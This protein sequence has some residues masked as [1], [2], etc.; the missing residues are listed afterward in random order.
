MHRFYPQL[1]FGPFA[2]YLGKTAVVG[3]GAFGELTI[4]TRSIQRG[5]ALI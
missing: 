5:N 3:V 2:Q 4:Q 1:G